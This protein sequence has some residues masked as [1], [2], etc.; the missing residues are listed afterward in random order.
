MSQKMMFVN[1]TF[2][3]GINCTVRLGTKWRS[4]N[5]GDE[6]E[7]V[8]NLKDGDGKKAT[9]VK[10][11]VSKFIDLRNSDIKCEHA[12]HC[13]G[14]KQLLFE[15][16]VDIYPN[17]FGHSSIVTVVYFQTFIEEDEHK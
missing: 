2:H 13:Q 6:I 4:L 3:D 15:D 17:K 10:V 8:R 12:P 11:L 1:P 16:M 5:P 9:V 14:N 7:L